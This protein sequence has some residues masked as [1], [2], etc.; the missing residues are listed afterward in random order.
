MMDGNRVHANFIASTLQPVLERVVVTVLL[1][2][3]N[4]INQTLAVIMVI[5][6]PPYNP[7]MHHAPNAS[8]HARGHACDN[9]L[10]K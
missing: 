2:N 4:N 10:I 9:D 6:N 1:H 7:D 8:F 5:K 3:Q